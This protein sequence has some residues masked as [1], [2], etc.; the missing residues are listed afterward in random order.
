[1]FNEKYKKIIATIISVILVFA[2][3]GSL[4]LPVIGLF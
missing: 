4:I 1:M 2:L 3:L